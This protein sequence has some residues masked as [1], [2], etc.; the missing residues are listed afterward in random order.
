MLDSLISEYSLK[1]SEEQKKLIIEKSDNK[2]SEFYILLNYEIFGLKNDNKR[3][4]IYDNILD[5]LFD[6]ELTNF[7]FIRSN[8]LELIKYGDSINEI[9]DKINFYCIK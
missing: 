3:E 6:N 7:E 2:I 8:I 9:I 5:V 4:Q 1:L